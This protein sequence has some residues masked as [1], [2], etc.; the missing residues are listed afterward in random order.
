MTQNQKISQDIRDHS[1]D[2][3]ERDF[4]RMRAAEL[5]N[6]VMQD[7][8]TRAIQRISERLRVPTK[9]LKWVADYRVRHIERRFRAKV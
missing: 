1:G 2:A 9:D 8:V 3:S 7:A 5:R 6:R 4:Y